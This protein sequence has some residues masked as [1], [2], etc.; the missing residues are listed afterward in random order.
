MNARQLDHLTLRIPDDS[1]DAARAFYGEMLGFP[2]EDASY[3]AGETPFFD[4]RL[5]PTAVVHLRPTATFDP[6]SD[7]SYDH[8]CVVVEE[9]LEAIEHELERAGIDIERTLDAPAGAT[10]RAGA[11]YVRD[12][13]GYRVELKTVA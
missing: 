11:V 10:G 8:L 1:E 9:S 7:A 6:P 13:F 3:R 5:S 2:I 12:P 4:V